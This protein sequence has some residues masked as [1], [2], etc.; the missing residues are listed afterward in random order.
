MDADH[1]F[2]L[3][4]EGISDVD[5]KTMNALF[6]AGC[7]DGTLGRQGGRILMGF[8]RSAP[9]MMAAIVSAINDVRKAGIG[10]RVVRV[11]EAGPDRGGAETAPIVSTLNSA[12]QV[13]HAI[14]IDPTIRPHVI[15]LLNHVR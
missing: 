6:E 3:I 8:T 10:A 11:E 12:L 15:S 9:T 1:E 2:V 14:E 5:S 7:D 4:L 13:S